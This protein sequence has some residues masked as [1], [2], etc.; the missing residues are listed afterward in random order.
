MKI[1]CGV[2]KHFKGNRY[3]VH[4]LAYDNLNN[5]F[6]FYQQDYGNKAFWIRPSSMF[7][8]KIERN[9]QIVQRFV[10]L[11]DQNKNSAFNN[12]LQMLKQ[13]SIVIFHSETKETYRIFSVDTT[14]KKIVVVPHQTSSSY[15]TDTQIAWRMG[16]DF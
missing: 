6:V 5:E 16:Y 7:C 3:I 2:Y 15:L 1:Q 4:G 8:E 11:H 14:S 12:L 10:F 9:G 13:N